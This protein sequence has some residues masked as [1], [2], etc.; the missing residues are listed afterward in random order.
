MVDFVSQIPP[1]GIFPSFFFPSSLL[2]LFEVHF[3]QNHEES[4][5]GQHSPHPE[6]PTVA[7]FG[8]S[9]SKL[10]FCDA[11]M[12]TL[13]STSLLLLEQHEGLKRAVIPISL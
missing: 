12:L 11:H 5:S 3:T 2:L 13:L 7:S 9:S 8:A 4:K 6:R 1:G 10:F